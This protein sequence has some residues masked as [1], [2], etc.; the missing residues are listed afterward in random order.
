MQSWV[1]SPAGGGTCAYAAGMA[2]R[3]A[4]GALLVIV[5]SLLAP[6]ALAGYWLQHT[7]TDP[8]SF[9]DTVAPLAE[10]AE[11]RAAVGAA[12]TTAIVEGL[13]AEGRLGPTRAGPLDARIVVE[14]A[15]GSAV[16]RFVEGDGFDDAW[17]AMT[18]GVGMTMAGLLEPDASGPLSLSAGTL[19]LDTGVV[20]EQVRARLVE[21][22]LPWVGSLDLTGLGRRVVLVDSP[23]LQRAVDAL[24]LILPAAGWLWVPVAALFVVGVAL[25]PDRRRGL[26]WTG[27]GLAL[28]GAA[29]WWALRW[30]HA[31]LAASA[32]SSQ[33]AVLVDLLAGAVLRIPQAGA[34]VMGSVGGALAVGAGLVLAAGARSPRA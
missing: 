7:L 32:G 24:R 2:G 15:V 6:V 31:T 12:V 29:L 13:A 21:Q 17:Q 5:A 22:G 14:R 11:V 23:E 27:I 18:T 20:V 30:A 34:L 28:A 1:Q 4:V 33:V 9:A 26:A 25:W 3:R 8:R 10:R 19:A 16:T